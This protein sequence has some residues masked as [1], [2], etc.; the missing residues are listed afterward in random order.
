MGPRPRVGA[1][2]AGL[3]SAV[4]HAAPI[5]VAIEAVSLRQTAEPAAVYDAGEAVP[6]VLSGICQGASR[7]SHACT[8]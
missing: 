1:A 4:R 8:L 2:A 6:A 5:A 7:Q 3:L